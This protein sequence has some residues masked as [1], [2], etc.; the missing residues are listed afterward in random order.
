MK[1]VHW[2]VLMAAWMVVSRAGE[3]AGQWAQCLAASKV[4]C[5]AVSMAAMRA[6]KKAALLVARLVV[7]R[8]EKLVEQRG[9]M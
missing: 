3:R 1:A 8:V 2:V 4:V 6:G 7:P 5:L 9:P